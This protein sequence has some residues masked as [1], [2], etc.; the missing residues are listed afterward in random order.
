[1][2]EGLRWL[3]QTYQEQIQKLGNAPL[4]G[5]ASGALISPARHTVEPLMTTRWNQG[6]PYNILCPRYINNDGTDGDPSATGCVATAIAQVMGYYRYPAETKRYIPS[7]DVEYDTDN[8][9]VKKRINGIPAHSV[10]DWDNILD[11]YHGSETALQDTAIAQLM[12]WVGVGCKMGYGPSSGAGFSAGVNA[13]IN[14]FGY[15]DG[16]HIAQRGNYTI[17]GWSSLLYTEIATGHPIA[18]AGTNT[19]GAHAFVL[20]GYDISGLFHLNWGWGGMDDGY[21][22]VDVLAPDNSSGI[23]ASQTPDGYNMGQEAIIGLR[24]PDDERA[25]TVQ[26]RLTVND[27]ELRGNNRF[28]ANYVNWSGVSA[29]WDTGIAYVGDDGSFKLIGAKQTDQLNDGYYVGKEFEVRGLSPGTYHMVPVSKRSSQRVWQSDVNPAIVYILVTVDEEGNVSLEKHPIEAISLVEL[30]FPGSH[31]VGEQQRV[32]AVFRNNGEEYSREIHLLASLSDDKG[33]GVCRTQVTI[34]EGGESISG[35]TF[36]PDAPGL[37]TVWLST[38]RW[39]NNIVGQGTVEITLEGVPPA[40]HLRYA[41]HSITNRSNGVVCGN[42]MQGRVT[43]LNQD[44]E[45]FVGNVRLWLFKQEN[46]MYYGD[47]SF[48]VPLT[49]E[50]RKT[51]QA[52]F[53][54]DHLELNTTYAMSILYEEGGDIQDG[55]LKP[56]GRTQAGI[57]YWQ[58]NKQLGGMAPSKTVKVPSGAVAVDLSCAGNVIQTVQVNENP[59][60][61]YILS[62]NGQWPEGLEGRNVVRGNVCERLQLT[63]DYGFWSPLVFTAAHAEYRRVA[64]E[65]WATIGLPFTANALPLGVTL[66]EFTEQDEEGSVCFDVSSSLQRNMPYLIHCANDGEFVFEGTNVRVSSSKEAPMVVGTNE[67][68]FMGT[69][70][71]MTF[72]PNDIYDLDAENGC[73]RL[74]DERTTIKPF[75]AWFVK[76]TEEEYLPSEISFD[77][78]VPVTPT[79][80]ESR[81]DTAA[82]G[83]SG[84]VYDLQGRVMERG[85]TPVTPHRFPLK[86]GIYVVNGK[87]VVIH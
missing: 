6:Y 53:D 77:T 73:F 78:E 39:G 65:G 5:T 7:Y 74:I 75:R 45:P 13:L 68:H 30:D 63:D 84:A 14:Y 79:G 86:K 64:E 31:K 46:G 28:F 49:I 36:T 67:H 8:G 3:L 60:T 82:Y 40:H 18:F 17:E 51:A 37:W 33:E 21:F 62:A 1:M 15:D 71:S 54:F 25:P 69:T 76:L 48:Y 16:T 58:Q 59:N 11:E 42:R 34:A 24:L 61:L 66:K 27:W 80:L 23:G 72:N 9:K 29:S 4:P 70:L 57:V 81:C 44:D 35:F 52:M 19:G 55:G 12:L 10:I 83:T 43:I 32:R 50:P 85:L 87:K 20:D 38:D 2:S 41:S 26:P 22:R 56:M 47:A